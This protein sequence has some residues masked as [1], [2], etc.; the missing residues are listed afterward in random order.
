MVGIS[1]AVVGLLGGC[2]A[3]RIN[4]SGQSQDLAMNEV[5]ISD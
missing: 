5:F 3:G 2:S 1:L 4:K